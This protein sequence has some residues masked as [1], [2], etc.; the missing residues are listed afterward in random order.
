MFG[1]WLGWVSLAVAVLLLI[2][3]VGWAA[4]LFLV[5]LWLAAVS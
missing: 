1:R 3:P 2:V 4:L 5:P